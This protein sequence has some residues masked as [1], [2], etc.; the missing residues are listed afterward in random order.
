M[1][2][3]LAGDAVAQ[4]LSFQHS[5]QLLDGNRAMSATLRAAPA[6]DAFLQL[7]TRKRRTQ[8]QATRRSD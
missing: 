4:R 6:V 3:L 8:K 1:R 5:D 2:T 7:L